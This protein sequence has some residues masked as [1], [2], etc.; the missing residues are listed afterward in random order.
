MKTAHCFILNLLLAVLWIILNREADIIH[1]LVG[2]G[3][4]FFILW[5][6]QYLL[7]TSSYVRKVKGFV[8]FIFVFSW[9]FLS[10]NFN[11]V[12]LILFTPKNQ[13]NPSFISY[14]VHDLSYFEALLISQFTTL[15]PGSV[16]VNLEKAVLQVHL[17][18]LKDL[19][20]AI[21]NI[22]RLKH[23]ILGFTR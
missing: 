20:Q 4:G 21:Q 3:I 2:Y 8:K 11:M 23:L 7:K 6:F 16:S 1:F 22:D 18:D 13:I 12:K 10:S 9:L 5:A 15:T 17:I 14:P 19:E